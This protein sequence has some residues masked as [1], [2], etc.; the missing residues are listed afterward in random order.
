MYSR[1]VKS[2][3]KPLYRDWIK[4]NNHSILSSRHR[5][6]YAEM[7]FQKYCTNHEI[8]SIK[9]NP[10][11]DILDQIPDKFLKKIQQ[12]ELKNKRI[13]LSFFCIEKEKGYFVDLKMGTSNLTQA[14]KQDI[15]SL[16]KNK[17]FLFRVFEDADIF[18]KKY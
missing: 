14:Q 6:I 5:G 11:I 17:I 8:L 16:N 15:K 7:I 9:I 10:F 13:S 4:E 1:V 3:Y 12:K 2:K 18:I